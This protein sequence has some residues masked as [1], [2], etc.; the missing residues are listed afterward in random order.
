MK[1]ILILIVMAIVG[2]VLWVLMQPL[3][4][5]PEERVANDLFAQMLTK[6][7]ALF[8]DGI[9]LVPTF[10][11]CS[12]FVYAKATTALTQA[13]NAEGW[14]ILEREGLQAIVVDRDIVL[15][16]R[17]HMVKETGLNVVQSQAVLMGG[18]VSSNL[19]LKIIGTNS[20]K[21]AEALG[22]LLQEQPPV[23]TRMT[24][25][26]WKGIVGLLCLLGLAMILHF[27]NRSLFFN[28]QSEKYQ[29]LYALIQASIGVIFMGVGYAFTSWW[30]L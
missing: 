15:S 1:S 5:T 21:L 26:W 12:D 17:P 3:P 30:L 23:R 29:T 8:V 20:V 6:P 18:C 28:L 16:H 4:E 22:S 10:P 13:A 14:D 7:P 9:G 27:L 25:S 11:G 19:H 24:Q 2:G